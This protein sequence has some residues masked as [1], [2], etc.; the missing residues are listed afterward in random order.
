MMRV[1]EIE[2]V[3]GRVPDKAAR[4]FKNILANT[5]AAIAIKAREWRQAADEQ[6][7]QADELARLSR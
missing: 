6:K 4:Q 2:R 7:K 3:L 1:K 5:A